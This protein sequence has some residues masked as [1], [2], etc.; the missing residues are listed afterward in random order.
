[1]FN[2]S[3]ALQNLPNTV[4]RPELKLNA[5][6]VGRQSASA[7]AYDFKNY[8]EKTQKKTESDKFKR[9]HARTQRRSTNGAIFFDQSMQFS[10]KFKNPKICV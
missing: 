7:T 10:I 8:D 3:G 9:N 5:E 2:C 1:V 6:K 4:L